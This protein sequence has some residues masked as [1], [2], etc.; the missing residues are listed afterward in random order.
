[1][2]TYTFIEIAE[3]MS[4]PMGKVVMASSRAEVEPEASGSY[5]EASFRAIV[6]EIEARI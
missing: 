2:K 6:K 4:V 5:S 1:M 3:I